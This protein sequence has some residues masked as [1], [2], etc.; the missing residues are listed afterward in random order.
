MNSS[1]LRRSEASDVLPNYSLL[2]RRAIRF[3]PSRSRLRTV[4]AL[5]PDNEWIATTRKAS[6]NARFASFRTSSHSSTPSG[7][8]PRQLESSSNLLVQP[9][10]LEAIGKKRSV[11]RRARSSSASTRS[12]SAVR[13]KLSGGF[14]LA[15]RSSSGRRSNASHYSTRRVDTYL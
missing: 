11:P 7:R 1:V 13:T 12:R 15:L 14:A 5:H 9:D 4:P 8:S 10:R 2:P 6:T 3:R